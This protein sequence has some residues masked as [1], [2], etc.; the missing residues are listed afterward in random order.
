MPGSSEDRV[1]VEVAARAVGQRLIVVNATNASEIEAAFATFAQR[2]VGALVITSGAF[3]FSHRDEIVALA[4][5]Y[6]L[7]ASYGVR[8]FAAAGV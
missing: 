8:E 4:A 2:G 5:R 1:D 7:P 6:G 3:T